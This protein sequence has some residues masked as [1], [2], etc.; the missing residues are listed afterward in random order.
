ML[1][2]K[3]YAIFMRVSASTVRR[4]MREGRIQTVDTPSGRKRVLIELPENEKPS[5]KKA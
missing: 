3:E 4:W 2:I 5:P 1:T